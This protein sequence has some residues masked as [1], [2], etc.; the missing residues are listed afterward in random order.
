M[1]DKTRNKYLDEAPDHLEIL[2]M[3]APDFF[4]QA[5]DN[6]IHENSNLKEKKAQVSAS[7]VTDASKLHNY[8]ALNQSFVN[9]SA[10]DP[11][12]THMHNVDK[13]I[14][15]MRTEFDECH[16]L[17][18]DA[19]EEIRRLNKNI[20]TDFEQATTSLDE[21]WKTEFRKSA[22]TSKM[23]EKASKLLDDI[24]TRLKSLQSS[25]AH[26]KN[27]VLFKYNNKRILWVQLIIGM[28][29]TLDPREEPKAVKLIKKRSSRK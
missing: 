24:Y 3:K 8:E 1:D 4:R 6:I 29:K 11:N 7:I 19:F 21:I 5:F 27:F 12:K 25:L 17:F 20:K 28:R 26:M 16:T 18:T 9:W 23:L 22:E 2:N 15:K 14:P 10:N 13:K